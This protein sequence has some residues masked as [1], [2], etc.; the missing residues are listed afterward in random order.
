M[1]RTMIR[2]HSVSLDIIAGIKRLYPEKLNAFYEQELDPHQLTILDYYSLMRN[3]MH[4]DE[5]VKMIE[6]AY[7]NVL[8]RLGLQHEAVSTLPEMSVLLDHLILHGGA[9][10]E[11]FEHMF[12]SMPLDWIKLHRKRLDV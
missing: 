3:E 6:D 11:A 2:N 8:R 7:H 9:Q 5:S 12:G 10:K 1:G 4:D